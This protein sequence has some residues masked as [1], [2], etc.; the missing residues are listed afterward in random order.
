MFKIVKRGSGRRCKDAIMTEGTPKR[1]YMTRSRQANSSS[2]DSEE[3]I[4][5]AKR[6]SISD[7]ESENAVQR[8]KRGLGKPLK[9]VT[10]TQRA[11]S[12]TNL[13]RSKP[14]NDAESELED[15][16]W[17]P[18]PK[19][20]STKLVTDDESDY[21][22][23]GYT[24]KKRN[25]RRTMDKSRLKMKH[26]DYKK[27]AVPSSEPGSDTE[28]VERTS[29]NVRRNKDAA[30]T[31]SKV[32]SKKYT[33]S[34]SKQVRF[35]KEQLQI[36][37][38][39]FRQIQ[40]PSKQQR[41]KLA[42]EINLSTPQVDRWFCH[43]RVRNP[44]MVQ[45]RPDRKTKEQKSKLK[46]VF[47][48][49]RKPDENKLESLVAELQLDKKTIRQHFARLR[50]QNRIAGELPTVLSEVEAKP[51]LMGYFQQDSMFHDYRNQE[52]R[53]KT[54][55]SRRKL[56]EFF[57]KA[58]KEHG[59]VK[60]FRRQRKLGSNVVKKLQPGDVYA[61]KEKEDSAAPLDE[62][63]QN[64]PESDYQINEHQDGQQVDYQEEYEMENENYENK[65]DMQDEAQGDQELQIDGPVPE[66]PPPEI[67]D[68]PLFNSS[69][70]EKPPIMNHNPNSFD[71][72]PDET[73]NVPRFVPA[74]GYR[75]PVPRFVP[76]PGYQSP[77]PR[78][79]P[80]PGY[81][82]RSEEPRDDVEGEFIDEYQY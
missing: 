42:K 45:S 5:I 49:I 74:P 79:V 73:K 68:I 28:P 10:A 65:I 1:V 23:E 50:F 34:P 71:D 29:R 32:D 81:R 78:F 40:H 15:N 56:R 11:F 4:P 47:A 61:E 57:E 41:E 51:I 12:R 77:V 55:W 2:L 24:V 53:K 75:S 59:I 66:N 43:K 21:D 60:L 39:V 17:D 9:N 3:D 25:E 19:R 14:S 6:R 63:F 31:Q 37:E 20:Q 48:G 80:A 36:L 33:L 69:R 13:R 38:T 35:S 82:D 27:N 22:F 54:G 70:E 8:V 52:L 16:V 64:Y 67:K 30:Q 7:S 76:A 46:E 44:K 62:E 72:F 18:K 26:S 58:R